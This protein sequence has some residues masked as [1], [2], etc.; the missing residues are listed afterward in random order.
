MKYAHYGGLRLWFGPSI[1]QQLNKYIA[2]AAK[3]LTVCQCGSLS[4]YVSRL[5][6]FR[7]WAVVY[8]VTFV[9]T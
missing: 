4:D 9:Q 5:N 6:S 2:T 8:I 1:E 3:I 7:S